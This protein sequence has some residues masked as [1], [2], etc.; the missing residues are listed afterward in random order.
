M[1]NFRFLIFTLTVLIFSS[2]AFNKTFHNSQ[3]LPY[4][5][6]KM[7][8]FSLKNDTTFI[9]YNKDNQEIIL[10]KSKN[11]I[12]NKNYTIRNTFFKSASGNLLNG[13][14]L[15]PRNTKPKALILH[16]HGSASNLLMHY[17]TISPLLAHGFQ[18]FTFDYSGYGYSEGKSTRKDVLKDA[19]S[20]LDFVIDNYKQNDKQ[21]IIYGHSY[22]GYLASIIGSNRQKN[23]DALVIE[24]AFSAHKEE[25]NYKVPILGYLVK[26]EEIAAIEIQKN[27]KPIL[28]IHSKEDKKVPIKFGNKIF[29]KANEPKE[30][31]EIKKGHI[32]GLQ[33][34][35][36][37]IA[38]KIKAMINIH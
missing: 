7:P 17:E 29:E 11:N 36:K 28:I 20:A 30:F 16:F 1:S 37:E 4:T 15:T 9:N 12:I 27:Y 31:F 34:Y 13:W 24:G 25:A 21:L 23:I 35:S 19:Y 8:S 2:C 10:S 14:L 32:L 3:K 6:D 18:V 26:N 5:I 22:G 33:Y 38:D